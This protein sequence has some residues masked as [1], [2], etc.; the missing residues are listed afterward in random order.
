M[1]VRAR[2]IIYIEIDG[3]GDEDDE[4]GK[5]EGGQEPNRRRF[6]VYSTFND[7]PIYFKCIE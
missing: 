3:D 5:G 1:W 4:Y 2:F 7:R 6:R